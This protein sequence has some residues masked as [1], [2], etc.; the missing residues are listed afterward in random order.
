MT[1]TT[2]SNTIK[3]LPEGVEM[4]EIKAGPAGPDEFEILALG[5]ATQIWKGPHTGA[6]SG[7]IVK[8]APGYTFRQDIRTLSYFPVKTIPSETIQ[9]TVK[10]I[11]TTDYDAQTVKDFLEKLK[12]LP[13]FVGVE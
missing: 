3:G 10:F 9:Q 11:V 2:P 5:G 12:L 7:I 6:A 4:V 13:G 8:P 1:P